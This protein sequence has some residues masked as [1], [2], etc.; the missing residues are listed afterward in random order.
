[1]AFLITFQA[2]VLQLYSKETLVQVD[3]YKFCE[4]FKN[5]CFTEKLWNTVSVNGAQENLLYSLAFLAKFFVKH[6]SL[7]RPRYYL[8][9][10]DVQRIQLGIQLSLYFCENFHKKSELDTVWLVFGGISHVSKIMS[11]KIWRSWSK[12]F[13]DFSFSIT[14]ECLTVCFICFIPQKENIK[15]KMLN[16]SLTTVFIL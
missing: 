15:M 3:S 11:Y 9:F 4:N 10:R 6:I 2:G 12:C 5:I 8:I 14:T 1:M 16:F 7:T 13:Q